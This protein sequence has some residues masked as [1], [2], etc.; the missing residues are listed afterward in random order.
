MAVVVAAAV[1]DRVDCVAGLAALLER[2]D[3]EGVVGYRHQG[4]FSVFGLLA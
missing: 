2:C 3:R 1:S 4:F